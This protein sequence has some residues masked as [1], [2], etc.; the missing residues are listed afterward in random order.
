MKFKTLIT[1]ATF[2]LVFLSCKD[3]EKS[4]DILPKQSE[5]T[6]KNIN[7][8]SYIETY[9]V[10]FKKNSGGMDA[11]GD[12]YGQAAIS[13]LKIENSTI[14]SDCGD[15]LLLVSDSNATI[16]LAIKATF[17]LEDNPTKEFIRAYIIKPTEKIAIGTTKVC[18]NG[19]E[20][21]VTREI[22]SAGFKK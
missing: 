15:S 5:T 10:L 21:Q 9:R 16:E 8:L 17:K 7:E 19:K 3:G 6:L 14:K 20:Y 4:K 22:V 12:L 18:Y 2:S 1:V 13:N 11:H